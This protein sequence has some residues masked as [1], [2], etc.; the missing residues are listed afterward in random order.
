MSNYVKSEPLFSEKKSTLD[1]TCPLN[2]IYLP[3]G[4]AL[5]RTQGANPLYSQRYNKT[6]DYTSNY[7]PILYTMRKYLNAELEN[8]LYTNYPNMTNQ[9]IANDLSEKIIKDNQKKAKRLSELV[10]HVNDSMLQKSIKRDI[11]NLLM[12][13]GITADYVRKY[14]RKLGCQK[15]SIFLR[16]ESARKKAAITNIKKWQEK[17]EKVEAPMEWFSTFIPKDTKVCIVKD[18]K[19]LSAIRTAMYRWNRQEGFA[20]GIFLSSSFV[21]EANL[22]RVQATENR[23]T[24]II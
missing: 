24:G 8:W 4:A 19:E 14:A 5:K 9:E 6:V 13:K 2:H 15:K 1:I 23:A 3:V 10:E 20:K 17:A 12:F 22:L 21:T 11:A 18:S 7:I 16:T